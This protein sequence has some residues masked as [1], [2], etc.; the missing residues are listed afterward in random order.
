MSA[1]PISHAKADDRLSAHGGHLPAIGIT[2][3]LL[4]LAPD[5]ARYF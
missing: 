5:L 4:E 3:T 1:A 2:L